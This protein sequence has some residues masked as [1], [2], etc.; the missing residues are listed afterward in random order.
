MLLVGDW[1][2]LGMEKARMTALIIMKNMSPFLSFGGVRLGMS[3]FSCSGLGA[4]ELG[5]D[6]MGYERGFYYWF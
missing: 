6:M 2:P 3:F 4:L 5:V 1:L